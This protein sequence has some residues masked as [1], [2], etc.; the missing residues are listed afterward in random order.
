MKRSL[1][2]LLTLFC[3]V[4]FGQKV[5]IKTL[6]YGVLYYGVANPIDIVVENTKCNN[7]KV[8]V[9]D[10]VL[11]GNY[12]SYTVIP[13]EIE[14]V[15][16]KVFTKQGKLLE[17]QQFQVK[18]VEPILVLNYPENKGDTIIQKTRGIDFLFKGLVCSD[19]PIQKLTYKITIIR[20][21]TVVF[22]SIQD[23]RFFTEE[24]IQALN[25]VITD[26]LV[27][28]TDVKLTL[29]DNLELESESLVYKV[30]K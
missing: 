22:I 4:L 17:K 1:L 15:T 21:D 16:I 18:P 26:D 10:E 19:I 20:N 2:I 6:E 24:V 27:L 25:E 12:C 9:N 5:L 28:F 14:N 13:K 29:A 11:E 8:L 23:K 3:S 30:K 7:F